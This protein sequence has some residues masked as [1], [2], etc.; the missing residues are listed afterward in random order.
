MPSVDERIVKMQFDNKQFESGI[1]TS[2]KSLDNLKNS[3]NF[4]KQVQSLSGLEKAAGSLSLS[5]LSSSV[6]LI[7]SRFTNLGIVGVRALQNITD[8]AIRT[9][10]QMVKSLTIDPVSTGLNEYETKMNAITTILTNTKSKGTTLDDV[11]KALNELNEYADLTIY[12][13]AEMTRNIGTFTA[14]GVDLDTSVKAIKGIANLAAGSGSTSAQASTAMYQLSQ[15]L[16]A[17][18]VSLQ[19]WNSV[20]NAGMGGELFQNALK[21]TAKQMGIV[22]DESVSFRESISTIGGKQSWLTSDVLIKTLEK[23]ADDQTLVDAATQVKTLTQLFD[24]MGES[25]QSGWAQ[26]WE[27]I[28]GNRDQAIETLTA[29]SDA[30]NEL[31]GPSTD[32]RNAMLKFW[33]ENGGRDAAINALSNAFHTLMDVLTPIHD[34]FEAVFPSM[35]GQR[36]VEITKSVES[37]TERFKVSDTAMENIRRTFEGLFSIVHIGTSAVSALA[38]VFFDFVGFVS[39]AGEGVLGL[40]AAL[41]D[42]AVGLDETIQK[43]GV[44]ETATNLASEGFDRLSEIAKKGYGYVSGF[45]S[46][47]TKGLEFPNLNDFKN[48]LSDIAETFSQIR[49]T[50]SEN[51]QAAARSVGAFIDKIQNGI[52]AVKSFASSVAK[53]LSPIGEAIKN[54]F[55]Q[56]TITDIVGTGLIAGIVLGVRKF[57]NSFDKIS[58]EVGSLLGNINGVLD[59]T[60]ASLEA[61][62]NNLKAGTLLKIAAAVGILAASLIALTMIDGNNLANGLMAVSLLLGEVVGTLAIL[63][64][65]NFGGVERAAVSMVIVSG[66]IAILASALGSLK[67]FQSWDKTWPALL[68]VATLMAGLTVSA[69]LMSTSVNGAEIMKASVGLVIFSAAIKQ[70]AKALDSFSALSPDEIKKSLVTLG[71]I[72]AEIAAFIKIADFT[73]LSKGRATIIEIAASMI[74][75]YQAVKLFGSMDYDVLSQGLKSASLMLLELSVAMRLIGSVNMKGVATS[76]LSMGAALAILVIPIQ[77]LGAMDL[78]SLSKG[79]ISL[80]AVLAA[81][82]I[83]I[84]ALQPFSTGAVAVGVGLIAMATALTIL[85]VPISVLSAIPLQNLISGLIGFVA[86]LASLGAVT[87]LLSPFAV[88]LIAVAGAFTL[89]GVAALSVGAGIAALAAGFATLAALGTAGAT[90]ITAALS[91]VLTGIASLGPQIAAA[92]AVSIGGLASAIAASAPAIAEAVTAIG[93]SIL[94]IIQNL[95]PGLIETGATLIVTLAQTLASHAPELA[96]AGL[97]LILALLEAI[98]SKIGD[99][100]NAGIDIVLNLV[101]AISSRLQD[102]ID[103]GFNLMISFING[104]ADS[105]RQNMPILLDAIGNLAGAIIEGLANG[106]LDGAG[107][108]VESVKNVG[109]RILQGFKD[110]FGIHSPS[111]VMN[112]QGQYIV[113]GIAE[114]IEENTSAEDAAT[115][116]AQNILNAFQTEFNRFDAKAEQA[117]LELELWESLYGDNAS[118]AEKAGAKAAALSK[119]LSLQTEKVSMAQAKYEAM[120]TE[121]GETGDEVQD[122]Y[123]DLLKQQIELSNLAKELQEARYM[124]TEP[125]VTIDVGADVELPDSNAIKKEFGTFQTDLSSYEDLSAISADSLVGDISE[126]LP[127][128]QENGGYLIGAFATGMSESSAEVEE[129]LDVILERSNDRIYDQYDGYYDA[130]NYLVDGFIRGINSGKSRAISAAVAIA[131]AALEAAEAELGIQSPSK[132]F[133]RVGRYADEGFANGILAFSGRVISASSEVGRSALSSVQSSIRTLSQIVEDGL[134]AEPTIRPVLDLNS[135]QSGVSLMNGMIPQS[136]SVSSGAISRANYGLLGSSLLDRQMRIQNGSPDVVAAV[137]EL[138]DRVEAMGQAISNLKIVMDTGATVGQLQ[139]KIDRN[140]GLLAARKERGI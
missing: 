41:G 34:A 112:E 4:D 44:F 54:M 77:T 6:D 67:E 49:A 76:L 89:F 60:R 98:A 78:N 138:S 73:S 101:N 3:L 25:V 19:D 18:R 35:T 109:N 120:L 108:V 96:N 107:R 116:K 33:N 129:A 47:F 14:A 16:A 56:V 92:F 125:G 118:D 100:V 128:I 70:L 136:I 2:M 105:V 29:V 59:Q 95:G 140:L 137:S 15:A 91:I 63:S 117:D 83:A 94:S 90:A 28:I 103:A 55:S 24:T 39:P 62:Q 53:F 36:L 23:F 102:I 45:V 104:L 121:F 57:L 20:V 50:A 66:A 85:V 124:Q 139:G 8:A 40:T 93:Q 21:E 122:A 132:E 51:M 87:V 113:E 5:N 88:A 42:F 84:A 22:V 81:L 43:Y 61:W 38:K 75:M 80:T 119:Q 86:I 11:N 115:K 7:A 131:R 27:Y 71:G 79:I 12:N 69:K 52:S 46:E 106:I 127:T 65:F 97:E 9:G 72:L 134:Q 130:G 17:G 64:K 82:S 1:Q 10:T 26:S 123:N 110:F 133:M 48:G 114:G 99:I 31:I 68:A 32:A 135:F 111:V 74:I 58:S 126:M 13:F 37:L 30:F